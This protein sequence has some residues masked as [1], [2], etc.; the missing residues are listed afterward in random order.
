MEL[1]IKEKCVFEK[2]RASKTPPIKILD[3]RISNLSNYWL[4]MMEMK[5]RNR[6]QEQ[7]DL[8]VRAFSELKYNLFL[9]ESDF[10]CV[11]ARNSK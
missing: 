8:C 7:E 10:F 11:D 2:R 9:L 5:T 3:T 1:L 6:R 4:D